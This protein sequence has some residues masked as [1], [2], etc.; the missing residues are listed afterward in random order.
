VYRVSRDAVR[1]FSKLLKTLT[2]LRVTYAHV[3]ARLAG[4]VE[5]EEKQTYCCYAY[6]LYFLTCDMYKSS[7]RHIHDPLL[8]SL[9]MKG[10]HSFF[11][12]IIYLAVFTVKYL[13]EILKGQTAVSDESGSYVLFVFGHARSL[14]VSPSLYIISK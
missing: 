9:K 14:C 13:K 5:E 2:L 1:S 11:V 7:L 12:C 6:R 4:W 10:I 3:W 8:S